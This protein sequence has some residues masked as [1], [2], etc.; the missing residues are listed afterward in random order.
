MTEE[1]ENKRTNFQCD[2][3]VRNEDD[4][5]MCMLIAQRMREQNI[6]RLQISVYDTLHT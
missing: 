6:L 3:A 4:V 1:K 5:G 2:I